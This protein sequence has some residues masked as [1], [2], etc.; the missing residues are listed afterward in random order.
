MI[1]IFILLFVPVSLMAND[2][3]SLKETRTRLEV[4]SFNFLNSNTTRTEEGGPFLPRKVTYCKKGKCEIQKGHKEY[5][6]FLKYEPNHPDANEIGYVRYPNINKEKEW[7]IVNSRAHHLLLLAEKK[8]CKTEISKTS[9]HSFYEINYKKGSVKA[10]KLLFSK[11]KLK[12]WETD[13][14]DGKSN[15]TFFNQ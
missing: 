11:G 4:S 3:N 15:I 9:N 6:T 13:Y 1:K 7:A 14:R 8:T 5:D 10:D 12:S 2:C